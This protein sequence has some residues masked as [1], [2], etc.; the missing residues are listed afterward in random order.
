MRTYR[1]LAPLLIV[2]AASRCSQTPRTLSFAPAADDVQAIDI[3]DIVRG[4]Q[5]SRLFPMEARYALRREAG[6]FGG[7]VTFSVG[8]S[9]PRRATENILVP[10]DAVEQFLQILTGALLREGY[11]PLTP[12][13]GGASPDIRIGLK[14]QKGTLTLL[15]RSPGPDSLPWAVEFD[16]RT[17][18][19]ESIVP[20]KAFAE[21]RPYLKR[22]VLETMARDAITSP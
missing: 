6:G 10:V 3:Q 5:A 4:P 8:S 21:L 17:Y 16:E 14:H 2:V 22:D 20:P 11:D 13:A 1:F 9:S 15:T 18:T 19:I 7:P 12:P